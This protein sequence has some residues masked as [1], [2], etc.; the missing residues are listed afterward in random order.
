MC[1]FDTLH[2][3]MFSGK[4]GVGKSTISSAFACRWAKEF[5]QEKILL[6]STDPA[7]SLGDVLQAEIIDSARDV[8]LN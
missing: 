8:N 3:A 4:G 1:F 5:P 6:I 2:L 7:H